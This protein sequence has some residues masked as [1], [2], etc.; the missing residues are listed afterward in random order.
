MNPDT[1]GILLSGKKK[2]SRV[3]GQVTRLFSPMGQTLK[4]ILFQHSLFILK[5]P[6]E[7]HLADS[8]LRNKAEMPTVSGRFSPRP[9]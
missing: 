3:T 6:Q 7:H 2:N 4:S 9:L 8:F 5:V 1:S